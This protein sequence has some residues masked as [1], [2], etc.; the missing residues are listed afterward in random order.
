[1]TFDNLTVYFKSK[2]WI[3]LILVLVLFLLPK[4]LSFVFKDFFLYN[5]QSFFY[6]TLSLQTLSFLFLA[7]RIQFSFALF[8]ILFFFNLIQFLNLIDLKI[9]AYLKIFPFNYQSF[10]IREY[11]IFLISTLTLYLNN[12]K[13]RISRLVLFALPI[14]N[15]LLAI[16]F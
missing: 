16:F 6:I 8:L 7:F 2:K 14:L 1:M 4:F 11:L 5:P 15:F 13:F 10:P 3:S 9:F 12:E